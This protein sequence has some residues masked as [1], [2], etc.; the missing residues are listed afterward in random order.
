MADD[1]N[2]AL[3]K[4]IALSEKSLG[5]EGMRR[6]TLPSTDHGRTGSE[7]DEQRTATS[8]SVYDMW[9]FC[10]ARLSTG[11]CVIDKFLRKGPLLSPGERRYLRLLRE[12][13][14]RLY[15]VEDMSPGISVTLVELPRAR[16]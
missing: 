11:G 4:L 15:E 1:R 12:T 16:G 13:A 5:R 14:L 10:D 8:E 7:L 2:S 9:F 6:N 3:A